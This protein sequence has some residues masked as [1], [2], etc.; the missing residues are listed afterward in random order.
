[1]L[2]IPDG[3]DGI[4]R[5]G[6]RVADNT[7]LVAA[8]RK[9]GAG[10]QDLIGALDDEGGAEHAA[11]DGNSAWIVSTHPAGYSPRPGD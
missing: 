6:A 2:A 5:E 4:A 10:I 8:L 7:A 9:I 3:R 1:M 11:A